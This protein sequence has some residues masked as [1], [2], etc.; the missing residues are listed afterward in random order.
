V[1]RLRILRIFS[2]RRSGLIVSTP[3]IY[4]MPEGGESSRRDCD[5]AF[6]GKTPP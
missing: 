1:C 2:L 5:E 4:T 6:R 3:G